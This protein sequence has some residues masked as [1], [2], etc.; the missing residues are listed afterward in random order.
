MI[1]EELHGTTISDVCFDGHGPIVVTGSYVD[2]EVR[3]KITAC[4]AARFTYAHEVDSRSWFLEVEYEHDSDRSLNEQRML[5]AMRDAFIRSFRVE[6]HGVFLESDDGRGIEIYYSEN[7]S[8]GVTIEL[9]SAT[10]NLPSAMVLPK[11]LDRF[12]LAE[13]T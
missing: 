4:E 6:N 13:E 12:G 7:G 3:W 9:S 11:D 2:E 5:W 1:L 10:S 8:N